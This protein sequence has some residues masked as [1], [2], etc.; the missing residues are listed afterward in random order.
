MEAKFPIVKKDDIVLK[1]DL[2]KFTSTVETLVDIDK[3]FIETVLKFCKATQ[4]GKINDIEF[5]VE[6]GKPNLYFEKKNIA[7]GTAHINGLMSFSIHS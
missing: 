4:G 5:K 1:D 6:N 2:P 7:D 3:K